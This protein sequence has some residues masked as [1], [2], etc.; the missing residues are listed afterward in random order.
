[1]MRARL[2]PFIA[3]VVLL[4]VSG[5]VFAQGSGGQIGNLNSPVPP[6]VPGLVYGDQS[7]AYLVYPDEQVSCAQGGFKLESVQMLLDF[8]SAQIPVLLT[9][10]GGL[11]DA[12]WDPSGE[13]LL[14]GAPACT[15][16]P[17]TLEINDPGLHQIT[18]P[19][20]G[21][22][23]CY[24]VNAPY[25]LVMHFSGPFQANLP[26]DGLPQP[27][28]VYVNDGNGWFDMNGLKRTSSGKVIIWGD[29]TCCVPTVGNKSGT[30]SGVK[31][32]YR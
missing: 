25:F 24:S 20:N 1:M 13:F 15:S 22:C 6:S 12:V 23:G 30:W 29:L 3:A 8:T 4:M 21:T 27:G 11:S 14:P 28:I 32:L 18:V 2:V 31:T 5:A 17:V 9:I 10:E 16:P 19:M 26:V 7:F